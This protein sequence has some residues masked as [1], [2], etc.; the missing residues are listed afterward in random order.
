[1]YRRGKIAEAFRAFKKIYLE[2]VD[3]VIDHLK[4]QEA[5]DSSRRNRR[6]ADFYGSRARPPVG[7]LINRALV[8]LCS[9]TPQSGLNRK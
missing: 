4:S 7:A 2:V 9:F 1:L 6:A 5:G 3:E 8:R